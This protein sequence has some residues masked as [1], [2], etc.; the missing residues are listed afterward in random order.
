M[1]VVLQRCKRMTFSLGAVLKYLGVTCLISATNFHIV[2][3]AHICREN[4]CGKMLLMS[5]LVF[6]LLS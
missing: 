4:K 3:K 2:E 5:K 1:I 6:I